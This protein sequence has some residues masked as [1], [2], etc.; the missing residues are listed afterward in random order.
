MNGG[1]S[2]GDPG[3]GTGGSQLDYISGDSQGH[4]LSQI[5][6]HSS[7]YADDSDYS[8]QEDEISRI[9][10]DQRL[11]D[12][13]DMGGRGNARHGHMTSGRGHHTH[14]MSHNGSFHFQSP[15][16]QP[17]SSLS[18]SQQHFMPP[19][20]IQTTTSRQLPGEMTGHHTM[21]FM[22]RSRQNRTPCSSGYSSFRSSEK[23]PDDIDNAS[24]ISSGIRST[25]S[26]NSSRVSTPCS[27]SD[28][29]A[30][31]FQPTTNQI[32]GGGHQQRGPD[33]EG[34]A[35]NKHSLRMNSSYP[36]TGH[37]VRHHSDEISNSSR[38]WTC[39]SQSSRYSYSGSELSD[40]ILDS[41][42]TDVRKNSFS[43]SEPLPLPESMQPNFSE[44]M[45]ME[46][47]DQGMEFSQSFMEHSSSTMPLRH[48]GNTSAFST[49]QH[50]HDGVFSQDSSHLS[51]GGGDRYDTY[52]NMVHHLSSPGSSIVSPSN[53]MV[54]GNM[55]TFTH[56]LSEE[57][58]YYDNLYQGR[59][60]AR[61]K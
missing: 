5:G 6:Y 47:R 44:G 42:P 60:N 17:T 12:P 11:S 57:T 53:N 43:K 20:L 4:P 51:G 38:G 34:G 3:Y 28:R 39:S 10:Q 54:I 49:S 45:G 8:F 30:T 26:T 25:V 40:D 15:P 56:T 18:P 48:Y 27:G 52:I 13:T 50:S 23:S 59:V 21:D 1:L 35:Y 14:V 36:Q 9:L 7:G 31:L 46:Y 58:Q 41:L 29:T 24:I 2:A 33:I 32:L 37:H 16:F 55:E 61:V 22:A 19:P